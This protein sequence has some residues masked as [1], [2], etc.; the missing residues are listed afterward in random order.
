MKEV[1]QPALG[2]ARRKVPREGLWREGLRLVTSFF[3]LSGSHPS[4]R[5][6]DGVESSSKTGGWG[7]GKGGREG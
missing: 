7:T 2:R 5:P 1:R 3:G 6:A 4:S